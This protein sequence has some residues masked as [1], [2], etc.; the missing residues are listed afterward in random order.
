MSLVRCECRILAPR[1]SRRRRLRRC[2]GRDGLRGC[3]PLRGCLT[4]AGEL[5]VDPRLGEDAPRGLP[6]GIGRS[7]AAGGPD[8]LGRPA[9][10]AALVLAMLGRD[11]QGFT[12]SS[13]EH[14]SELQSLMRISYAVF[15]LK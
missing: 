5:H 2:T 12:E 6:V 3:V 4:G 15:C 11:L 7:L 1:R 13:A 10:T 14:T 8:H 9:T